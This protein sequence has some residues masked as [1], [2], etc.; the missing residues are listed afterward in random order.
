MQKVLAPTD[1][2]EPSVN[3]VTWAADLACVSGAELYVLHVSPLPASYS[4]IPPPASLIQDIGSKAEQ[5]M[6][7]LK[8]MLL[9]HTHDSIRIHTQISQGD[10][11]LGIESLADKI[12]P[13]AI[14]M[15]PERE[16]PLQRL[17]AGSHT[18]A[19]AKQSRYPIIVV[20]ENCHFSKLKRIGLGVELSEVIETIPVDFIRQ[21]Q[22]QFH[23][24]LYVLH[25]NIVAGAMLAG[26][27][28]EEAGWLVE[29]LEDLEPQ[30][31]YLYQENVEEGLCRYAEKYQLDILIVFP[32]RRNSITKLFFQGHTHDLALH[33][34]IPILFFHD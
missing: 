7:E 31:H 27:R 19:A 29:L 24:S 33:S 21:L 2:S 30:Y 18:L 11:L 16:G 12:T 1:F 10:I 9:Q 26:K 5:R 25:I 13:F 6:R 8:E 4:E 28:K 14:V 23:A 3:A 17:L 34:P 22:Q 15:G 32:H 20:P